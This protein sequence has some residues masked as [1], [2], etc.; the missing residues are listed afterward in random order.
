[1]PR[2][3]KRD[4][5]KRYQALRQIWLEPLSGSFG[6]LSPSEQWKVHAFY[7]PSERLTFEEFTAHVRETKLRRPG[8]VHVVGKLS[9]QILAEAARIA[10]IRPE[11]APTVAPRG[12]K[13][14][15]QRVRSVTVNPVVRPEPDLHKLVRAM[16][17]LAKLER[18]TQQRNEQ[19]AGDDSINEPTDPTAS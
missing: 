17:E 9:R 1:M 10:A 13:R 5:Y 14:R 18:E 19:D 8:L 7:Q 16:I 15:I 2:V 11:P 6:V 12:G 4:Q 3:T